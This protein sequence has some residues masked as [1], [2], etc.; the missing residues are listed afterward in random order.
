MKVYSL[1][2]FFGAGRTIWF[3]VPCAQDT[4]SASSCLVTEPKDVF[5]VFERSAS[6]GPS[7][8]WAQSSD[9]LVSLSEQQ[10][11]AATPQVHGAVVA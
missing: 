4:S 1:R 6:V 9:I 3:S 10:F 11:V 2:F 8:A 7:G 5:G